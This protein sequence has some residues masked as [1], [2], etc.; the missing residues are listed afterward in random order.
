MQRFSVNA[1]DLTDTK[2]NGCQS[3]PRICTYVRMIAT[4]PQERVTKKERG[5]SKQVVKEKWD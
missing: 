3:K 5:C 4:A 1:Q 2:S